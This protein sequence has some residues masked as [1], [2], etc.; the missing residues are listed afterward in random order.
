MMPRKPKRTDP[1]QEPKVWCEFCK[2]FVTK[3]CRFVL[4][5]WNYPK[6][7]LGI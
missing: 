1:P 5:C 3:K 2:T 7:I 4:F 6:N